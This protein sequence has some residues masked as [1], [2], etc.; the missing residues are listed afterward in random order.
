MNAGGQRARIGPGAASRNLARHFG[1]T[2]I[3]TERGDEGVARI[4]ELTGGIGADSVLE[5][6]GTDQAMRQALH[7]ARP[8]GH[9]GFV[10]VPHDVAVDGQELFLSHVALRAGPAP[11]PPLPT[12]STAS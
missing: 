12:S 11:V 5:C 1:A 8:G 3:V 7:S 6:V 4:K 10:G 9:V 2:G